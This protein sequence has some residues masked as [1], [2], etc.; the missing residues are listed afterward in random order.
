MQRFTV[1]AVGSVRLKEP[2]ALAVVENLP[3]SV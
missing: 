1:S 3:L 2:S